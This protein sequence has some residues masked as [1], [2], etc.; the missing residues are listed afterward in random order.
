MNFRP[1]LLSQF[2]RH[3]LGRNLFRYA[4]ASFSSTSGAAPDGRFPAARAFDLSF[5]I[6]NSGQW[7]QTTAQILAWLIGFGCAAAYLMWF[8]KHVFDN[9]IR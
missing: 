5:L 1:R 3:L 7:S 4:P 9:T 6:K 8:F 2:F